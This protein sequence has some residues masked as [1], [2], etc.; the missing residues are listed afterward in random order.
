MEKPASTKV[1]C[2]KRWFAQDEVE[3]R[4][5]VRLDDEKEDFL[6]WNLVQ[7]GPNDNVVRIRPYP[8]ANEVGIPGSCGHHGNLRHISCFGYIRHCLQARTVTR[9]RILYT[10]ILVRKG[11]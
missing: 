6:C 8:V 11:K 2:M 7:G 4:G 9:K 5:I 3:E 1:D 10:S